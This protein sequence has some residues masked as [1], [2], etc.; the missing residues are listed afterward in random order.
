MPSNKANKV[1]K[2]RYNPVPV[3]VLSAASPSHNDGDWKTHNQ[4]GKVFVPDSPESTTKTFKKLQKTRYPL[5]GDNMSDQR[6]PETPPSTP[7]KNQGL[8]LTNDTKSQDSISSSMEV[9]GSWLPS[10]QD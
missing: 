6:I 2:G 1:R 8:G 9:L 4:S 5:T 7:E 3:T 10:Q